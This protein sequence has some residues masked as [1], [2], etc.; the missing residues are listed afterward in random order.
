MILRFSG[1]QASRQASQTYL[2][3]EGLRQAL[4]KEKTSSSGLTQ[5]KLAKDVFADDKFEGVANM[6]LETVLFPS[7]QNRQAVVQRLDQLA[8]RFCSFQLG[9]LKDLNLLSDSDEAQLLKQ[10]PKLQVSLPGMNGQEHVAHIQLKGFGHF[11]VVFKLSIGEVNYAFKCFYPAHR[12]QMNSGP[13]GEAAMA[14]YLTGKGV[15]NMPHLVAANP[16]AGWQL[17]EWVDQKWLQEELPKRTGPVWQSLGLNVLDSHIK[18]N[19]V[20]TS[21]GSNPVRLDY[22]HMNFGP[23]QSPPLDEQVKALFKTREETGYVSSKAFLDLFA[24]TPALRTVLAE[25]LMCLAP[26][27]R[28][29]ILKT[30]LVAPELKDFTLYDLHTVKAVS[31]T[32]I[33]EL[34]P[35]LMKHPSSE[36]QKKTL[37]PLKNLS[38]EAQEKLRQFWATS[39]AMAWLDALLTLKE[40]GQ[41]Q[42]LQA[43]LNRVPSLAKP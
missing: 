1:V 20:A 35:W 11:G 24:T 6:A 5:D 12:E 25:N 19:E 4:L 38:T 14:S 3:G 43:V 26:Q 39:P 8:S 37:L 32:Q 21:Q 10:F 17:C 28:V 42:K 29:A 16:E 7:S 27:K 30:I 23:Y 15:S 18:E 34:L 36:I 9:I 13:Y 31:T 41:N 2:S 33:E 40:T 22:G